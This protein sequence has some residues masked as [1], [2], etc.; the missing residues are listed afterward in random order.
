MPKTVD[1]E[2]FRQELLEKAFSLFAERGY[3][4]LS[5]KELAASLDISPGLLYRYFAGKEEMFLMMVYQFAQMLLNELAQ[6]LAPTSS[7]EERLE[8]VLSHL[9]RREK[10][11]QRLHLALSDFMRI[12]GVASFQESV[13]FGALI[14]SYLHSVQETLCLSREQTVLLVTYAEGVLVT[15]FIRPA[16][17]SFSEHKRILK[18]LLDR[19]SPVTNVGV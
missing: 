16:L 11:F 19:E 6:T 7:L 2:Q 3:G 4:S 14:E 9:E 8:A 13:E 12:V 15:R 10:D 18:H 5:V 17:V 1:H